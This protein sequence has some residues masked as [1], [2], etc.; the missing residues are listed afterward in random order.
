MMLG[1]VTKEVKLS[2]IKVE[3]L[4]R[5][6]QM[7]VRVTKVYKRERLNVEN[8]NDQQLIKAYRHLERINMD[9]CDHKPKL[10]VHLILGTDDYMCIKTVSPPTRA[11][12]GKP[13]AEKAK[14]GW[15]IRAQGKEI[16][17][18]ALL[19]TQTSQSDYE[20]LQSRSQ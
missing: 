5:I 17:C 19:L 15:T 4:D 2:T 1:A 16:D 6:F 10:P 9:D 11:R 14:F 8:P 3:A 20:E 13:V 7:N 18:T 12:T